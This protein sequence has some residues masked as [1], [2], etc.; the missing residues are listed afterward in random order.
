[1]KRW[2]SLIVCC[3]AVL[4]FALPATS[5]PAKAAPSQATKAKQ[6]KTAEPAHVPAAPIPVEMHAPAGVPESVKLEL[7]DVG[8]ILV[9]N[10]AKTIMP[11]VR[12]KEVV[13]GNA[14]GYVANYMEVD[15]SNIRAE[16]I[17]SDKPGKYVGSIRYVEHRYECPGTSKAEAL[18]AKCHVAQSRRMNE[19]ISYEKG[20][21][22]Y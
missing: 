21:W 17:P 7:A 8:R 6:T 14:G 18:Q 13:P 16:V 9:T 2:K 3:L 20:K 1:M 10:A 4:I 11:N 5:P 15:A 22:H 12:S 19:L